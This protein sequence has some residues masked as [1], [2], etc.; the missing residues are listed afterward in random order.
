[1][2]ANL[3]RSAFTLIELLVVIT[4]IA[5]LAGL[6][7]PGVNLVREA[8]RRT[9]CGSN[10]SQIMKAMALYGIDTGGMWPVAV[11][12]AGGM[13]EAVLGNDP[14]FAYRTFEMIA[15]RSAGELTGKIFSC[16][17]NRAPTLVPSGT[18][19]SGY[20][21]VPAAGWG[22]PTAFA[23][24]YAYDP[25]TPSA[26]NSTRVIIA[27]RPFSNSTEKPSNHGRQF[28]A[29]FADGHVTNLKTLSTA[30]GAGTLTQTQDAV[31]FTAATVI[32]T[33]ASDDEVFTDNDD[34]TPAPVAA[35]GG[36][37]TRAFLR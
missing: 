9:N 31:N 30:V 14:R 6:L 8:A 32:N 10:Q 2:H 17:S 11:D 19:A 26:A 37:A 15:D 4:I 28:V 12:T 16:P 1:M 21:A 7:L 18:P 22:G 25:S 23:K 33:D 35:H 24:A 5:I 13:S 3:R 29:V 36:S 20:D 34:R 27:D